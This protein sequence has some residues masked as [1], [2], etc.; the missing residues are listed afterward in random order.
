MKHQRENSRP[1]LRR[2]LTIA[3]LIRSRRAVNATQLATEL[4]CS[5]KTIYRDLATLRDDLGMEL[6]FDHEHNSWHAGPAKTLTL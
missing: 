3:R 1:I 4:E 6:E 5:T 2:L